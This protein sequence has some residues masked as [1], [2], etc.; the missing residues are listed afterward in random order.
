LKKLG[1]SV[2]GVDASPAML[3]AAREAD[4]EIET[5]VANAAALPFADGSFDCVI[6]FMSLQD[7]DESTATV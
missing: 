3:A 6:A 1:H 7:V 4:P 2:V 5:H